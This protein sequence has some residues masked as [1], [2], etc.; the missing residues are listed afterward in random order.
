[1]RAR[2]VDQRKHG[3]REALLVAAA[4][5]RV[6]LETWKPQQRGARAA[7]EGAQEVGGEEASRRLVLDAKHQVAPGEVVLAE[8]D[9]ADVRHAV[10]HQHELAVVP[11]GEAQQQRPRRARE[12]DRH[13]R[14]LETREHL[15]RRAHLGA[16]PCVE[17]IRRGVQE[18][19]AHHVPGEG[20]HEQ[21]PVG[22]AA[23]VE[24]FGER[25]AG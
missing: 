16:Q 12:A 25:L 3:L 5:E 17:P 11:R 9:S 1:M 21:S 14:P 4:V 8:V 18:A 7:T 6:E 13:A 23:R 22:G 15:P 19:V 2:A 24:R 10:V 20:V